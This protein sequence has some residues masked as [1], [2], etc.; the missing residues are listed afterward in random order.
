MKNIYWIKTLKMFF[1]K[2]FEQDRS[3]MSN[4]RGRNRCKSPKINIENNPVYEA[5]L[6][7]SNELEEGKVEKRSDYKP[8]P[9]KKIKVII[10]TLFNKQRRRQLLSPNLIS[11]RH[12]AT[13]VQP[14]FILIT[15]EK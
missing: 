1:K 11:N 7:I 8:P 4:V 5:R 13:Q 10:P 2:S 9:T 12:Q 6:N 3:S 15:T 14:T